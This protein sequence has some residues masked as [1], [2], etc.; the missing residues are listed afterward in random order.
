[1]EILTQSSFW[2]TKLCPKVNANSIKYLG[3]Y[4]SFQRVVSPMFWNTPIQRIWI[5]SY[6]TEF[7]WFTRS[8]IRHLRERNSKQY[9]VSPQNHY[10]FFPNG[11]NRY[12]LIYISRHH[13]T[14]ASY[15]DWTDKSNWTEKKECF[16]NIIFFTKN[17]WKH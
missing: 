10:Q 15:T 2:K 9:F 17:L 12:T 1:M 11:K 6:Y 14:L 8:W 5:F 3:N 4:T 13:K 16:L 7:P